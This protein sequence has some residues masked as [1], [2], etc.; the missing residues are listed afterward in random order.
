LAYQSL[1]AFR[2]MSD[3]NR[4]HP[5]RYLIPLGTDAQDLV[6]QR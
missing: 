3:S 5:Q 4:I 6:T 1:F 2:L